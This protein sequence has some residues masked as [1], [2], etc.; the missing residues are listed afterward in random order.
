MDGGL[1]KDAAPVGALS[2]LEDVFC[3]LFLR[4]F[5]PV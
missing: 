2:V 3:A 1:C 4:A 5:A